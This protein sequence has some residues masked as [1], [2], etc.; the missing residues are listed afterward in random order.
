MQF[1]CKIDNYLGENG[2]KWK[3]GII[4]NRGVLVDLG[5]VWELFKTGITEQY[6]NGL[7][8]ALFRV[9]QST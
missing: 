4:I 3:S 5:G 7:I 1:H 8:T 9:F 6:Y 2:K